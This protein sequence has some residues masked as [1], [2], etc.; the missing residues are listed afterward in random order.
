MRGLDDLENWRSGKWLQGNEPMTNDAITNQAIAGKLSSLEARADQQPVSYI[1]L[2]KEAHEIACEQF[3]R[4]MVAEAE[5]HRL[6]T[7]EV[8]R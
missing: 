7:R 8:P 2:F 3:R 1:Q 4:A 6:T 5:I